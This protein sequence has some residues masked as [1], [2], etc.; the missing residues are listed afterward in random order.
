MPANK[1]TNEYA[2]ALPYALYTDC[3]KAVFAAIAVS[4]AT[5]GGDHMEAAEANVLREWWTLYENGIVPQKPNR[6][7]PE[8]A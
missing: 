6:A 5:T 8:A 2:D 3:P 4:Y 1:L 7:K